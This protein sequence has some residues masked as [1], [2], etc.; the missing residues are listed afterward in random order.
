MNETSLSVFEIADGIKPGGRFSIPPLQRGLV[1]NA[2]R[3]EALW[4]SV[5]RGIPIGAISIR[6]GEIF[7]SSVV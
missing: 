1:W 6:N 3:M 4:D 5:L 7:G 2:A